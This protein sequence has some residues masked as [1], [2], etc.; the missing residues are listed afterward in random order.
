MHYDPWDACKPDRRLG[1]TTM[2]ARPTGCQQIIGPYGHSTTL[3]LH[4][5]ATRERHEPVR[6]LRVL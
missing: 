5:T 6:E 4:A 1:L 2:T 3:W